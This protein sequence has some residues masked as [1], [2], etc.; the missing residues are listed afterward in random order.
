MIYVGNGER[1]LEL[2]DGYSWKNKNIAVIGDSFSAGGYWQGKMGSIL[3]VDTMY[4][5]ASSGGR[6][7]NGGSN[8][9]AYGLAT[10]LFNSYGTMRIDAIIIAL[11]VND[12]GNN[13]P[14]GQF[15]NSNN[16][17]DFDETTILGGLQKALNY[18]QSKFKNA[19]IYVCFTPSGLNY[20]NLSSQDIYPMI[21]AITKVCNNYG[22]KY[23]DSLTCGI[24]K[25]SSVYA[26]CWENGNG[27]GHPTQDGHKVIGEYMAYKLLTNY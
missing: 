6:F 20:L 9:Y 7:S 18:L 27:G 11:G 5:S 14:L 2:S 3:G 10:Q 24:T 4:K 8:P 16:L 15:V 19:K 12:Y 17:A 25:L 23:I 21:D 13:V 26:S 22:V 1:F